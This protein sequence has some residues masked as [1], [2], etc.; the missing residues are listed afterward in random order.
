MRYCPKCGEEMVRF[1][2]LSYN[3]PECQKKPLD[4]K[5]PWVLVCPKCMYVEGENND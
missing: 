5:T 3:C 2:N 4:I 1:K